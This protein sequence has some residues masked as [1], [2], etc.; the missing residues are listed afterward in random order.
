MSILPPGAVSTCPF[1]T[2]PSRE[3]FRAVV[4]GKHEAV[5]AECGQCRS[6]HVIEPGWLAEAYA[7]P[8]AADEL[9][10][11]ADWRNE[12]LAALLL[13]LGPMAPVGPWLDYGSGRGLLVQRLA[14]RGI[15]I[16]GHDPHRGLS[17]P[18]LGDY[19]IVSSF[20]V[21]EHCVSPRAMLAAIAAMLRPK[22]IVALSTWLREPVH[23]ASWRY[24]STAAG[25]HVSFASLAGLRS[26]CAAAGI[27]WRCSARNRTHAELQVHLCSSVD[28]DFQA[29]LERSGFTI[30]A[31]S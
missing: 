6:L 20:E 12:V 18:E 5:Y 21:L 3:I 19:A 2:A 8:E 28:L 14:A 31:P 30:F 7:N 25:Q 15:A 16:R 13:R 26:A 23:D 9:D 4:M 17:A 29:V 11:G 27:P 24:L 1:C 22:G 10:S